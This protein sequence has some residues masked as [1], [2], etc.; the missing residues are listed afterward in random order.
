MKLLTRQASIIRSSLSLLTLSRTQS[1]TLL[2]LRMTFKFMDRASPRILN[3]PSQPTNLVNSRS[4]ARLLEIFSNSQLKAKTSSQLLHLPSQKTIEWLLQKS[5]KATW[6]RWEW[7]P[8]ISL[9]FC[10]AS[11]RL[12]NLPSLLTKESK[13]LRRPGRRRT[14]KRQ[15]E[16]VFHSLLPSNHS[17]NRHFLFAS[18]LMPRTTTS[19]SLTRW[20]NLSRTHLSL[21]GT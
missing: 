20:R 15:L 19:P 7:E 17:S 10:F 12:T 11:T 21:P 1:S 3:R 18:K 4:S 14:G 8:S 13:W 9:I 2:S 16:L 6:K 5:I